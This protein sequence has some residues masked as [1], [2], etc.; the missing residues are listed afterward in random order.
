MP[1]CT[2]EIDLNPGVEVAIA[3]VAIALLIATHKP[4]RNSQTAAHLHKQHRPIS[5]RPLTAAQRHPR[6][7]GRTA[8][9]IDIVPI[10]VKHLVE[11]VEEVEGIALAVAV[12]VL[13]KGDRTRIET[14]LHRTE[15][16][17]EL[18]G[19]AVGIVPRQGRRPSIEE[20]V[21]G[22]GLQSFDGHCCR[23]RQGGRRVVK[24]NFGEG[25]AVEVGELRSPHGFRRDLQFPLL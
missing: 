23:D 19:E 1:A 18:G 10:G 24:P 20:V 3:L 2:G 15:V 6:Q 13:S 5:T 16:G 21:K 25:I 7:P 4:C 12:E 17:G 11:A 8:C 9:P 22:V 14:R